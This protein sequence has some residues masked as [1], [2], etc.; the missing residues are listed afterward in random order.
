MH[1]LNLQTHHDD[2]EGETKEDDARRLQEEDIEITFELP[3]QSEAR[4]KFKKGQTVMVL[5]SFLETEFD[6]HMPSIRLVHNDVVL[7]D[8]YS[9]TDYPDFEHNDEARVV[10]V[11]SRK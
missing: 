6:L 2:R 10:V 8:P 11:L 7:L 4:Q 1:R 9:L 3:D 5:K